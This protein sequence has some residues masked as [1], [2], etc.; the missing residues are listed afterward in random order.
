MPLLLTH[1][2]T[3]SG[4][5]WQPNLAALSAARQV[6]TW[7]IRG[8]GRTDTPDD[9]AYYSTELCVQDMAAVL[10]TCGAPRAVLGGLSLGGY[11]SLE[12]YLAYPDRVAGLVLCDT[13]PGYRRDEAREQW[14]QRAIKTAGRYDSASKPGL[15]H[16]ARGILTQRDARVMDAL[17]GITIPALVVVG[18]RDE[19]YLGAA[20]YMAAKLPHAIHSVIPDAGHV[21][22]VD[23]PDL[24]SQQL[25]AFLDQPCRFSS[26]PMSSGICGT[27]SGG[28]W[29]RNHRS[30]RS[31]G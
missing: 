13:G 16:A 7:D 21:S 27:W 22:N 19:Q 9:P 3:G 26:L 28:S 6:V 17:P 10:D 8:H 15:A 18:A 24:F 5:D 1:G 23:Q 20:S 14:N 11:L 25:L 29:R 2:F 4:Q 31:G 12:F 30:A